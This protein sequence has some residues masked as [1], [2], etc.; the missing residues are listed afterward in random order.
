VEGERWRRPPARRF[1]VF[2]VLWELWGIYTV[3]GEVIWWNLASLLFIFFSS[4]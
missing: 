3:I 4:F 2:A 1:V